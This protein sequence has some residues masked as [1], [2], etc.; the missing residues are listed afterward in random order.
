MNHQGL[1]VKTIKHQSLQGS[2]PRKRHVTHSLFKCFRQ[3]YLCRVKTHTLT[4]V[5]RN[6]PCKTKW[7]LRYFSLNFIILIN[8]PTRRFCGYLFSACNPDDRIV[9]FEGNNGTQSSVAITRFVIIFKEK[10]FPS[11]FDSSRSFI[12]STSILW[13]Y[14]FVG[15]TLNSGFLSSLVRSNFNVSS[16][17]Q[18]CLISFSTL[19]AF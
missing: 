4:F 13:V 5:H 7:N 8:R 18:F 15:S 1:F 11:I 12:V 19:T 14:S 2:H 6:R 16:V 17:T 3:I 10:T 9:G